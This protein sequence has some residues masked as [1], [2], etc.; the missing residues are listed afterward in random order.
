MSSIN[1][2]ILVTGGAE[3]Y[4][5]RLIESPCRFVEENYRDLI[6]DVRLM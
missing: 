4:L 5:D 1:M 2:K 3:S 6:F